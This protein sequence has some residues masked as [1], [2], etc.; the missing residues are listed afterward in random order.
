VCRAGPIPASPVGVAGE[1]PR[2]L[3]EEEW[4]H[5]RGATLRTYFIGQCLIRFP[6]IYRRWLA[7]ENRNRNLVTDDADLL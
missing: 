6:N 2:D 1:F 3:D 5:R 7:G 4:D